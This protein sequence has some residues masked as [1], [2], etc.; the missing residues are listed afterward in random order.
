M[1]LRTGRV[2]RRIT[3]RVI[4]KW[5]VESSFFRGKVSSIELILL[6]I[7]VGLLTLHAAVLIYLFFFSSYIFVFLYVRVF[8]LFD[9]FF[10]FS[11]LLGQQ[12]T[13]HHSTPVCSSFRSYVV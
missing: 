13:G 8:L 1:S 6:D 4:R 2:D 5:T 12:D 11:L 10:V 9:F 7:D 3:V